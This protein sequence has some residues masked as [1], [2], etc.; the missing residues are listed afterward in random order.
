MANA[1][2]LQ[3]LKHDVKS[4]NEWRLRSYDVTIDLS[5]DD[6]SRAN[7][8]EANLSEANL[9]SANLSE[10]NLSSANLSGARLFGANLSEAYLSK[11]NLCGARIDRANLSRANLSEANL[12]GANLSKTNFSKAN[13]SKA[14]LSGADLRGADLSG[15]DLSDANLFGA[16]LSGANLSG[17]DLSGA[18][19]SRAYLNEADLSGADLVGATLV[20]ATLVGAILLGTILSRAVGL[21]T[22]ETAERYEIEVEIALP[23]ENINYTDLER[24]QMAIDNLMEVCEFELKGELDPIRGSWWQ[25]LIFWSKDKTTPTAVNRI[26]QTL[27]EVFVARSI[28][29]PSAEEATKLAEAV[30]KVI[31]TLEPFENGVVRFGKLLVIKGTLRGKSVLRVE[32]ISLALAQKLADNPQLI[33]RPEQLLLLIEEPEMASQAAPTFAPSDKPQ[34]HLPPAESVLQLPPSGNS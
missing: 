6:L 3:R 28:G 15:T 17:A 32:T 21:N 30:D 18:D 7:L 11:A 27:K 16:L 8:S 14:N 25:K 20:G 31:K 13:L 19:L 12:G 22:V 4:W 34:E 9:S 2:H 26:F 24:L 23:Q 5:E 1:E 33:N 10:A 29:I